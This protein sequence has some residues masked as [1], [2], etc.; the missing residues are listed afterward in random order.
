AQSLLEKL[1]GTWFGSFKIRANI[2]RFKRGEVVDDNTAKPRKEGSDVGKVPKEGLS[3]EISFK[4]AL[5]EGRTMAEVGVGKQTASSALKDPNRDF[6]G[7]LEVE[8]VPC[9]LQKLKHCYVG[10]LREEMDP[11][12]LQ[13][14]IAMEGFQNI[15]VVPLGVDVFLLS[16]V[17]QEGVKIALEANRDWWNQWFF[18]ISCWSSNLVTTGRRVWVR[19][20]GVPPHAWGLDCFTKVVRPAGKF[21]KLDS[22]T[23]NLVRLDVARVLIDQ[24]TW[25]SI[26]FVQQIKV[27]EERFLVKVVEESPGDSDLVLHRRAEPHVSVDGSSRS[28]VKDWRVDGAAS[29]HGWREGCSD[30]DSGDDVTP[31]PLGNN[32]FQQP[33]TLGLAPE[34]REHEVQMIATDP[35]NRQVGEI[36]LTT[37]D[38][39]SCNKGDEIQILSQNKEGEQNPGVVCVDNVIEPLVVRRCQEEEGLTCEGDES[40]GSKGCGTCEGTEVGP[41]SS[42]LHVAIRPADMGPV[43]FLNKGKAIMSHSELEGVDTANFLLFKGGCSVGS[44]GPVNFL[45]D[46]EL[47]LVNRVKDKEVAFLAWQESLLVPPSA[48]GGVRF[49]ATPSRPSRSEVEGR[50]KLVV[51]SGSFMRCEHFVQAVRGA[52]GGRRGRKKGRKVVSSLGLGE[53]EESISNDSCDLNRVPSVGRKDMVP[54]SSLQVVLTEEE[55]NR[56]HDAGSVAFRVEAE[57]LF[58]IGLNLGC[59]SNEERITMIER[60]IDL[61]EKEGFIAEDLGEDDGDQ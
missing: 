29:D 4:H 46:Q 25:S 52:K 13:M 38:G 59:T 42:P 22:Q 37:F 61:E 31:G 34:V 11:N 8:P 55:P 43:V 7:V 30:G 56:V 40:A 14:M 54:I 27:V 20:F 45:M 48:L 3:A 26:D 5:V 28:S 33:T 21:I 15:Q 24:S 53:H 44:S 50:K 57:G 41:S 51:P 16:S 32:Q 10:L 47:C 1:E 12:R 23:E 58:N 19:V 60:L 49:S 36:D 17:Q 9:N 35:K 39:L 6:D 2:S 18:E